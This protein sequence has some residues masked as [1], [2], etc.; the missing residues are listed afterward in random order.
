MKYL[1]FIS[2]FFCSFFCFA[3]ADTVR[4]IEPKKETSFTNYEVLWIALLGLLVLIGL[5]FWFWKTRKR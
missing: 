4:M 1:L 5:W 2:F 3:Q